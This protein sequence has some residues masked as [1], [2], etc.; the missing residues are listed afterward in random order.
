MGKREI[1]QDVIRQQL[2]LPKGTGSYQYIRGLINMAYYL[3]YI[4]N[5]ER[6]SLMTEAEKFVVTK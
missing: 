6:Q 4:D 1:V 5:S 2:E 3:D